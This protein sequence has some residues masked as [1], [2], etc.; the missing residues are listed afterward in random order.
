MRLFRFIVASLLAFT[1]SFTLGGRGAYAK[2]PVAK[3]EEKILLDTSAFLNSLKSVGQM[4]SYMKATAKASDVEFFDSL[5]RAVLERPLPNTTIDINKKIIYF[6]G[7]K[8][9]YVLD[10]AAGKYSYDDRRFTF[11]RSLGADEALSSL[12]NVFFPKNGNALFRLLIPEALAMSSQQKGLMM[13]VFGAMGVMGMRTVTSAGVRTAQIV[14][15]GGRV[16]STT[17]GLPGQF[18]TAPAI[19]GPVNYGPQLM[20]I[21]GNQVA[22]G[23]INQALAAP[24]ILPPVNAMRAY[25]NPPAAS[26]RPGAPATQSLKPQG[27]EPTESGSARFLEPGAGAR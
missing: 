4:V 6:K 12:E 20:Q 27:R 1:T 21:C 7:L 11:D 18:V 26:V 16:L 22:L 15:P 13:G 8:P 24:P 2:T 19:A 17:Q 9:I 23:N 5:D 10:L 14:G 25:A 3:A